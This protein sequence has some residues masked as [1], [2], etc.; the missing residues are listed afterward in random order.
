MVQN[1]QRRSVD[2]MRLK[3]QSN[4]IN[5]SVIQARIE[6]NFCGESYN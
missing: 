1:Q 2:W 4:E 6:D 3:K 5:S